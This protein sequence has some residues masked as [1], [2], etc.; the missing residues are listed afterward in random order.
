MELELVD[1]HNIPDS[2]RLTNGTVEIVATTAFGPRI[3]SYGYNSER[4][5]FAVFDKDIDERIAEGPAGNTWRSYGGH[6]LWHAP[7]TN[8]RTYAPDNVPVGY[9]STGQ[10]LVL[11]PV[12]EPENGLAKTVRIALDDRGTGVTIDHQLTNRGPWAI[13]LAVWGLSVMAPGGTLIVPQEEFRPHPDYLAP[14]RPLVLWH[15]TSMADPR[16]TWGNRCIR[17]RQDDGNS[18]KLKFGVCNSRGWAAYDFG[19]VVFVKKYPYRSDATYPDMGCNSEFYT[20]P[21]FLEIESLSPVTRV[22][23][24]ETVTHRE[25][26]SLHH[27]GLS[28]NDEA[29]TQI[30]NLL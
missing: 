12:P 19:D 11:G 3:L 16:L 17:M 30:E 24:A 18:D 21:G 26:W 13:E 8:P 15:Y 25:R 5:V 1:F 27:L 2:V 6:R 28:P 14:A 7:E 9:T 4:N 22:E 10:E 20:Q 29:I 23:P